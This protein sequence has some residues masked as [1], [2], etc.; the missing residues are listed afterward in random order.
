MIARCENTNASAYKYYGAKGVSVCAEWRASYA[1]FLADMGP[2]PSAA[3]SLDRRDPR[4]NYEPSNCQWATRAEQSDTRRGTR[5]AMVDGAPVALSRL[6]RDR[7]L[8][9]DALKNRLALGW[10][11]SV[12]LA[13]PVRRSGTNCKKAAT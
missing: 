7:G 3:H 9:V 1:K 13:T 6:A 2:K 10:D 8:S 12:A 4:G 5:T 11:L